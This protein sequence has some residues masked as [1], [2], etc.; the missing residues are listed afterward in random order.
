MPSDSGRPHRPTKPRNPALESLE[1][2]A[3]LSGVDAAA[4]VPVAP[5]N[6]PDYPHVAWIAPVPKFGM[7]ADHGG[8]FGPFRSMDVNPSQ[9]PGGGVSGLF[10]GFP[11]VAISSTFVPVSATP[12]GGGLIVSLAMER[13]GGYGPMALSFANDGMNGRPSGSFD[14]GGYGLWMLMNPDHGAPW[15]PM[16]VDYQTPGSEQ[17]SPTTSPGTVW[18][19]GPAGYLRDVMAASDP[20]LNFPPPAAGSGH[21]IEAESV[22]PV[23]RGPVAGPPVVIGITGDLDPHHA[24]GA[25]PAAVVAASGPM[26]ASDAA[27]PFAI[28]AARARVESR[29]AANDAPLFAPPVGLSA[30]RGLILAGS[31]FDEPAARVALVVKPAP[32]PVS[33]TTTAELR[34]TDDDSRGERKPDH[35]LTDADEEA[36]R[37]GEAMED[38]A[39]ASRAADL[40]ASFSPFDRGSLEQAVDRFLGRIGDLDA[41]LSQLGETPSLI[42]GLVAAAVAIS[43]AETMRR[44]FRGTW[45]EEAAPLDAAGFPCMPGHPH[46]WAMEE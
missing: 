12:G 46:V 30:A 19:G 35:R 45:D 16:A 28:G 24:P 38:V 18:E 41:E 25:A 29:L 37:D 1:Y 26:V 31:A 39:L 44:R 36:A 7:A 11:V 22:P 4:P 40:L 8:A 42:P 32:A 23:S 33:S 14:R 34:A 3:L 13:G 43:V 6:L 5:A 15:S 10:G 9:T 20:N 2:R 17:M 27:Q 21:G